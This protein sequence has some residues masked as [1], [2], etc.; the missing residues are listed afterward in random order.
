MRDPDLVN[1]GWERPE[2]W[3]Y[4]ADWDSPAWKRAMEDS[5][6]KIMELRRDYGFTRCPE[7]RVSHT[8]TTL[9]C[10]E[11]GYK[12]YIPE[13]VLGKAPEHP[14]KMLKPGP[15]TRTC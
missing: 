1:P 8:T 10:R 12:A 6:K 5:G 15:D 7:C 14:L 3:R 9:V 4:E 11:C 13:E 2:D